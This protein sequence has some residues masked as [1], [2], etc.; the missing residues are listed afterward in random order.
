MAPASADRRRHE[1]AP[2]AG[3]RHARA[4]RRLA[5]R[6]R[7]LVLA[8]R[9]VDP[10]GPGRST[11]RRPAAGRQSSAG[12]GATAGPGA[13]APGAGAGTGQ[14]AHDL[15]G[16][17]G[18]RQ[19]GRGRR[20]PA[21][22]QARRRAGQA[23]ACRRGS[24]AGGQGDVHCRAG[25]LYAGI[26]DAR[27]EFLA[28]FPDAAQSVGQALRRAAGLWRRHARQAGPAVLRRRLRSGRVPLRHAGGPAIA[29]R[30]H[31]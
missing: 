27:A 18:R 14:G 20:R 9:R 19:P 7:P 29:A 2:V 16:S 22:R 26:S 12:R 6:R 31:L 8:G 17:H 13:G 1:R 15:D 23:A 4:A 28:L 25:A 3:R 5:G 21:R 10:R 11:C 30:G 24:P